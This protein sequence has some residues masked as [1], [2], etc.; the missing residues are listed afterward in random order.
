MTITISGIPSKI[1]QEIVRGNLSF[2]YS[3]T[4][5]DAF[6]KVF[7]KEF[8]QYENGH[9]LIKNTGA[10]ND[11]IYQVIANL[12][13]TGQDYTIISGNTLSNGSTDTILLEKPYYSIELWVKSATAGNSTDYET[14]TIF[15]G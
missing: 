2:D 3:G 14:N 1:K 12:T 13:E 5:T 4:T 11:L 8:K 7:D 15:R 10:T 9:I 6:V